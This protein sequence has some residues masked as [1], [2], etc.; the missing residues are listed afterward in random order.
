V[1]SSQAARRHAANAHRQL[2]RV[3][4]DLLREKAGG[5]GGSLVSLA[6]AKL[7]LNVSIASLG[8]GHHIECKDLPELLDAEQALME[9]CRNVK[10]FLKAAATFNG[11]VIL[12]DFEDDERVHVSQGALVLDASPAPAPR[13]TTTGPLALAP[14]SARAAHQPDN[15]L[16][17]W[18][19]AS[20][21]D[22]AQLQPGGTESLFMAMIGKTLE[23]LR[24]SNPDTFW[25]GL[26]AVLGILMA[27]IFYAVR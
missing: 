17:S 20:P 23:R 16:L 25:L 12:V 7:S 4:S 5:I 9:A 26:S 18:E 27:V 22:L 1:Y 10:Q 2:D 6:M 19:G 21:A 15:A 3:D 13:A 14:P 8:R 11:S 24:I